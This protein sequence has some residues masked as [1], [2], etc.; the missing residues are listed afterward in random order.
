MNAC[1]TLVQILTASEVRK[2]QA[3]RDSTFQRAHLS[4]R[5]SAGL[6]QVFIIQAQL[7]SGCGT[8]FVREQLSG[9][10]LFRGNF[11]R[12]SVKWY[13]TVESRTGFE[14]KSILLSTE[15]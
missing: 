14:I 9:I 10:E 15:Q 8:T 4:S 11:M 2:I 1:K 7:S 13:A 12:L 6:V 5:L 3:P